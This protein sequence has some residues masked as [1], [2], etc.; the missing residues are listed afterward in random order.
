MKKPAKIGNKLKDAITKNWRDNASFLVKPKSSMSVEKKK[1]LQKIKKIGRKQKSFKAIEQETCSNENI[2]EVEIMETEEE[3]VPL[4]VPM[5][6][7]E[8]R[9]KVIKNEIKKGKEGRDGD[10]LFQINDM[11]EIDSTNE[12]DN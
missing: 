2:G 10:E 6:S 7:E 8:I 4:S 5:T 12:A 1:E 3:E 9:V 11:M